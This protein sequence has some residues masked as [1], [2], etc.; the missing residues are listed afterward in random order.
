MKE[1]RNWNSET[2]TEELTKNDPKSLV[3][4]RKNRPSP[5]P[6]GLCSLRSVAPGEGANLCI[7]HVFTDFATIK[8]KKFQKNYVPAA[9]V[10]YLSS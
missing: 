3:L 2:R 8:C 7:L 10:D 5:T 6:A 9:C 1:I 4:K